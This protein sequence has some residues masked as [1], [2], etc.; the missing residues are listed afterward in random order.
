M[1]AVWDLEL[2]SAA[3][4]SSGEIILSMGPIVATGV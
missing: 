1:G 4:R 3:G 2:W